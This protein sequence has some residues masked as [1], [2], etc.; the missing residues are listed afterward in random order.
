MPCGEW[1][2]RGTDEI[3]TQSPGCLLMLFYLLPQLGRSAM[4]NHGHE[5]CFPQHTLM[6]SGK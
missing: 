6:R 3:D 1:Y 5:S 2:P 4:D